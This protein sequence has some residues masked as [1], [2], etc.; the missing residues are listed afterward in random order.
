MP[1]S[2][3]YKLTERLSRVTS[4]GNYIAELD[5]LRFMAIVPVLIQHL[6][7]RVERYSTVEWHS[8]MADNQVA[9]WAS[10]GTIG[11]FIFFAISG[12]ILGLPFAK[13]YLQA[14][15]AVKLPTYFWRRI[16]RLEPP[17]IIWMCVFFVVLLVKSG[18]AFSDLWPHLAASLFYV[19]NIVFEDYSII[20]PVAWSL[21][22]EIQFYILAPLLAYLFFRWPSAL[23]RRCLLIGSIAAILYTQSYFGWQALPYKLSLLWQLHYF[24][25]GFLITDLFLTQWPNKAPVITPVLWDIAALIALVAMALSWSTELDKRF[26]FSIALLVF[27]V[28]GFRGHYFT[29]FLRLPWVAIIGG[30]C[31]TIYLIHLPLLEGLSQIT[32]HLHFTSF[33]SVNLLL[34]AIL[35]LP[36]VLAVSAVAFVWIEKPCMD[37]NWPS[38]LMA[39]LSAKTSINRFKKIKES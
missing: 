2:S 29:A 13:H 30:M 38:Q 11:V 34:Q 14:N 28:A 39:W 6:S 27:M 7:E 22:I 25:I 31:Y 12:F 15:R 24:L 32:K 4:S 16:T 19:H 35:L 9:F 8:P 17:Y 21:E 1:F 18:M 10:R 33:F 5:G 23:L 37:K 26:V 20:N 36:I 3:K